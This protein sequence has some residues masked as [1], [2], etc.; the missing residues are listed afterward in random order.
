MNSQ[1]NTNS[2]PSTS[3]FPITPLPALPSFAPASCPTR[4]TSAPPVSSAIYQGRCDDLPL[5]YF[6]PRRLTV[7]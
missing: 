2:Q 3:T 4:R 7:Y 5:R 6:L 1:P